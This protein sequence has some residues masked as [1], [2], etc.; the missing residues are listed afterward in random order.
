MRIVGFERGDLSERAS[1]LAIER[2]GSTPV[3]STRNFFFPSMPV[4]LTENVLKHNSGTQFGTYFLN[5][6]SERN[7]ERKLGNA[8]FFINFGDKSGSQMRQKLVALSKV[9]TAS[10]ICSFLVNGDKCCQINVKKTQFHLHSVV[11]CDPPGEGSV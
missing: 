3:G 11:K 9:T 10:L 1:E 7:S 2:S 5:A 8:F 6:F 4:S